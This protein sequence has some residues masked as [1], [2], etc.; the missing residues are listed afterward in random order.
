MGIRF[1]PGPCG[2]C[3]FEYLIY[4]KYIQTTTSFIAWGFNALQGENPRS[5]VSGLGSY[6]CGTTSA[7]LAHDIL[8]NVFQP[9]NLGLPLPTTVNGFPAPTVP[10][11]QDRSYWSI[12]PD[13][14]FGPGGLNNPGQNWLTASVAAQGSG[15]GEFEGSLYQLTGSTGSWKIVN[16]VVKNSGLVTFPFLL[17][18]I[19]ED[20]SIS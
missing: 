14:G 19:A 5:S 3:G 13:P 18:T 4:L 8:N 17:F 7:D 16:R 20:G 9:A 6:D 2:C 11:F 15:T 10:S 12:A 1:S